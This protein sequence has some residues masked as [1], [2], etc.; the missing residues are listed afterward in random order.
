[1]SKKKRQKRQ[2]R[3]STLSKK[4][5]KGCRQSERKIHKTCVKSKYDCAA[6]NE[7][8]LERRENVAWLTGNIPGGI[9]PADMSDELT[10]E[11]LEQIL[12]EF[13]RRAYTLGNM[14]P[15]DTILVGD[16]LNIDEQAVSGHKFEVT[17]ELGIT[18]NP[19]CK[20]LSRNGIVGTKVCDDR[21]NIGIG[22]LS[23]V[24]SPW[25]QP[26]WLYFEYQD[27]V[28]TSPS[29]ELYWGEDQ[30]ISVN[31]EYT[32][33]SN[34]YVG[35]TSELDDEWILFL[36]EYSTADDYA[37]NIDEFDDEW[38]FF[39]QEYGDEYGFGDLFGTSNYDNFDTND[40]EYHFD[41]NS[42][43]GDFMLGVSPSDNF[44]TNDDKY[45]I[46]NNSEWGDFMLGASPSD[47]VDIKDDEYNI[48]NDSEWDDFMLGA[49]PFRNFG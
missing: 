2:V 23:A 24:H 33:E 5:E 14:K 18:N 21:E 17:L 30:D 48:D 6:I 34:F 8:V 12:M 25:K 47:N 46:D 7:A 16:V 32:E 26:P 13:K 44:D 29:K 36:D 15:R 43:W 42:E 10:I 11:A 37:F 38:I 3:G 49:S 22:I 1:M 39:L 40:D 28:G 20:R 4:E 9:T 41:N 35:P 45:N 27:T 19:R 31:D